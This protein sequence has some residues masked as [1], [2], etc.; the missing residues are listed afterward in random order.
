MSK[1]HKRGVYIGRFHPFHKGHFAVIQQMAEECDEII[2][3]VGSAEKNYERENP[4]TAGER[5]TMIS[6][7]F[8]NKP[9]PHFIIPVEDSHSSVSWVANVVAMCP[10]FD[11]L[12]SNN[13]LTLKIFSDY[14]SQICRPR[15]HCID[16]YS[17]TTIRG[18]M[19]ENNGWKDRIPKGVA[20]VIESC[21]GINRIKALNARR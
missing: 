18:R 4:F 10:S 9:Y 13:E 2:V 19:F 5:I 12:Y 20:E 8:K 1:R 16:E 17:G 3:V 6:E 15:E 21:D 14:G 7:A 11:I